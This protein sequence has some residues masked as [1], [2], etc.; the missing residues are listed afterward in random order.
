MQTCPAWKSISRVV[1]CAAKASLNWWCGA[2]LKAQRARCSL[3]T[4]PRRHFNPARAS[5][6]SINSASAATKQ[7]E[8]RENRMTTFLKKHS[9]LIF[10]SL[11]GTLLVLAWLFPSAGLK[12]GIAFLLLI[13]FIASVLVLEKHK[14]AYRTGSIT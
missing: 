4:Q 8:L 6:C 11:L 9:T 10:M 1:R 13:F 12:L 3:Q 14:P 5:C 7:L 2:P